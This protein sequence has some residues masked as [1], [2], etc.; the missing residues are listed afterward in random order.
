[1]STKYREVG[2][3]GPPLDF[4]DA[5]SLF[6]CQN[7]Q[8]GILYSGILGG[9]LLKKQP[10]MITPANTLNCGLST[11]GNCRKKAKSKFNIA[12]TMDNNLT[13]P[14]ILCNTQ[15]EHCGEDCLKRQTPKATK[16]TQWITIWPSQISYVTPRLSTEENCPNKSKLQRQH[17]QYSGKQFGQAKYPM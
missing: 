14:N 10:C 2:L 17:Y 12:H 9:G 6:N 8:H 5:E 4:L 13:E 1:M 11:A 16:P 3:A 15:V 7:S